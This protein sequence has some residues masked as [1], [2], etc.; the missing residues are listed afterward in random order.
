M[1]EEEPEEVPELIGEILQGE[2]TFQDGST[3]AGEYLKNGE[4]VCMHGEGVLKMGPETF[5]GLFEKGLYKRGKYTSCNG[6]VY[7]GNFLENRFH[8]VGEYTWPDGRVYSGMFSGGEMHGMGEFLNFSIGA[9]KAFSGFAVHGE[10]ASGLEEQQEARRR[11]MEEYR[12]DW[13]R[14][15]SAALGDLA[16]RAQ[17]E[18]GAP[19]DYVVPAEPQPS[20]DGEPPPEER[21]SYTAARAAA[22]EAVSGAFPEAAAFPQ[23][24]VQAFAA[25]LAKG[26]LTPLQVTVFEDASVRCGAFDG[27]RLRR[28]QLQCAGQAVGFVAPDAEPGAICAVVLANTSAEYDLAKAT[29]KAVHCEVVPAA[30]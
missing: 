13:T 22:Q 9:D 28:T 20:S 24:L 30:A 16:E 3:Y 15:A 29:W 19:R 23:A 6:S 26:A 17:P 1:K 27:M 5:Q 14:S 12:A 2:F 4:S 21:P 7:S 25:G 11:F 8:G 18:S 10:F